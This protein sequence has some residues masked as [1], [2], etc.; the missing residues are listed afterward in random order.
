MPRRERHALGGVGLGALRGELAHPRRDQ[1]PAQPLDAHKAL[2]VRSQL[3]GRARAKPPRLDRNALGCARA[4][5]DDVGAV[6]QVFY[7]DRRDERVALKD[8][9]TRLI[10]QDLYDAAVD[11]MCAMNHDA[12]A[13]VRGYL[14]ASMAETMRDA[15]NIVDQ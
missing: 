1:R 10:A 8:V 7:L 5:Q 6:G 15:R 13:H 9:F 11:L 4:R 3:D 12:V 14:D 2:Q